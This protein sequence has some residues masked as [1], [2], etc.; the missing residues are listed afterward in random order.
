MVILIMSL[1][2]TKIKMTLSNE[3]FYY[4][5]QRSQSTGGIDISSD[6]TKLVSFS[7]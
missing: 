5:H 2:L 6:I 1:S 4:N 3:K 7:V